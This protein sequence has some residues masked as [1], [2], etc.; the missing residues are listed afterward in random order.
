MLG[1]VTTAPERPRPVRNALAF[2]GAGVALLAVVLCLA[3]V[4][5]TLAQREVSLPRRRAAASPT[6]A[7]PLL[8]M[9]F[10]NTDITKV[11]AH[12]A[13]ATGTQFL[14]G[15]QVRG[16]ITMTSGALVSHGEALEML[17]ISL[18]LLGFGAL[19]TPGGPLKIIKI[20][21]AIY[22]GEWSTDPPQPGDSLILT[23]IR[24]K[25]A[26]S[27][28]LLLTLRPLIGSKT[29]AIDYELTNSLI[30]G[31]SKNRLRRLIGVI[32]ALD[33]K[34]LSELGVRRLRH[35]MVG[36]VAQQLETAFAD[37][38]RRSPLLQVW[39]DERTNALLLLGPQRALDRAR[40]LIDVIDRSEVGT[41]DIHVIPIRN[42]DPEQIAEL[43]HGM[44]KQGSGGGG[45]KSQTGPLSARQFTVVVDPPTR[46]LV[47]AADPE[48]ARVIHDIVD[49]LDRAAPRVSVDVIVSEVSKPSSYRLGFAAFLPFATQTESSVQGGAVLIDPRGQGFQTEASGDIGSVT[50]VGRSPLEIPVLDGNGDP[51]FDGNGAP[52]TLSLAREQAVLV[53]GQRSI[54]ARVLMRPHLLMS[55]GEQREIF[56]G[57]N[58]PI[59]RQT[60]DTTGV[61]PLQTRQTI[62]RQDVGLTLRV[63]P[64]VG[65][66]GRV[67]LEVTL[68]SKNVVGSIAGDVAD[69][70][71]TI[72]QRQI[73]SS[74]SLRD[75]EFAVIGSLSEPRTETIVAGLPWLMDLPV[76][77][78]IFRDTS[79]VMTD[80]QIVVA[81]QVRVQRTR[82]DMLAESIRRRIGFQRSLERLD[83]LE[84]A[85]PYAVLVTTRETEAEARG[86]AEGFSSNGEPA[87]VASWSRYDQQHYDV[88]MTGF[89]SLPDAGAAAL[90]ARGRGWQPQVVAL[91]PQ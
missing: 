62:E 18:G 87:S 28:D 32:Q 52:V 24:L 23:I 70:G 73:Q 10:I 31:G 9:K 57:A 25:S 76:L 40:A 83:G 4:A 67:Q 22:H 1:T 15:D 7:E 20:G 61:I 33:E 74:F 54:H 59:P 14:Y 86:I 35:S 12:V 37:P 68:E 3:G 90:R 50:R 39:T 11:I 53:A 63:S 2:R 21:T 79:E 51:V 85:A 81:V 30:L 84:T 64:T 45:G 6:I 48:T 80:T 26:K 72:R 46:S 82:E 41:G 49:R 29:A 36:D 43:L 34:T 71:P 75:G 13:R 38:S 77:G 55:S 56:V 44:E 42:A 69:V 60:A 66:A 19:S 8:E 88:Y 16:K 78:W 91:P 58:V 17:R 47:V 5:P 89:A 27:G 65:E